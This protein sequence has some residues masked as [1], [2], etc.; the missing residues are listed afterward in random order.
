MVFM[1]AGSAPFGTATL[2]ILD[3]ALSQSVVRTRRSVPSGS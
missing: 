2:N 1:L 3:P